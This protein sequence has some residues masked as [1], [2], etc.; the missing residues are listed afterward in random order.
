MWTFVM[1]KEAKL[2]LHYRRDKVRYSDTAF[3]WHSLPLQI[4]DLETL[5]QL[6]RNLPTVKTPCWRGLME[7]T[8]RRRNA[9]GLAVPICLNLSSTLWHGWANLQIIPVDFKAALLTANPEMT[10]SLSA[11]SKFL[12]HKVCKHKRW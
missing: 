1:K 10:L 6:V 3:A 9:Q 2:K 11:L 8:H 7:R 4:C 5:R 12:F